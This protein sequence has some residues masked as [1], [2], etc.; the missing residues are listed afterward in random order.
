VAMLFDVLTITYKP[1]AA[2]HRRRCYACKVGDC[3]LL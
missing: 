1:S 3:Y 2:H